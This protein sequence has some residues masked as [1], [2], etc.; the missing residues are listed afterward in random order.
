MKLD[1]VVAVREKKTVYLDGDRVIKVF[2]EDYSKADVL[3]EALNHARVEE[4][5]LSIPQ[6]YEVTK[7][8][9]KWAIVSEYIKGKTLAQLM[10]E[11]PENQRHLQHLRLQRLQRQLLI[12]LWW[13]LRHRVKLQKVKIQHQQRRLPNNQARIIW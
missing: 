5:G 13:K 7:I 3:N 11:N 1:K 4:T 9:G 6:L 8:D 12:R 2:N 10:Q